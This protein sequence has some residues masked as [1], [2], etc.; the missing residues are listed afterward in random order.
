MKTLRFIGVALLTVLMSVGF[1][2]CGG[3]DD[4]VDNG[5][6]S[7][8]IEGEWRLKTFKTYHYYYEDGRKT[9]EQIAYKNGK[10][11]PVSNY[12][13]GVYDE[14]EIWTLKKEGENIIIYDLSK[15]PCTLE[16][17]AGN[18]YLFIKNLSN[19]KIQYHRV[20]IKRTSND[21]L[22][23]EWYDDFYEDRN[24]TIKKHDDGNCSLGIY[25]LSKK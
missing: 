7:A 19:G 17:V 5:S 25:T 10:M 21:E 20:V 18:E 15:K 23:I 8:S 1:S 6:S 3:D 16:K 24:G 4:D 22:I 9:D 13:W 14:N 11:Q 2:A 12:K